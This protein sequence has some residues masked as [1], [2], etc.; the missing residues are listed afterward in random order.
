MGHGKIKSGKKKQK[1]KNN[2]YNY[3][4]NKDNRPI[5]ERKRTILSGKE[6]NSIV[7]ATSSGIAPRWRSDFEQRSRR[8]TKIFPCIIFKAR[9]PFLRASTGLDTKTLTFASNSHF[10]SS[11]LISPL[12]RRPP[13]RSSEGSRSKKRVCN[14]LLFPGNLD[15]SSMTLGGPV[16]LLACGFRRR[17]NLLVWRELFE[18]RL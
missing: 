14:G 13:Q 16:V 6:K 7:K 12:L 8:Q 2:N 9:F 18:S 4:N 15:P 11:L 3:N 1:N 5:E 10:E 17:D